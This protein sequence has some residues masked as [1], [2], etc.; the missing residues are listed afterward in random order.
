MS[1]FDACYFCGTAVDAPIATYDVVP[2]AVSDEAGPTAA[3]CPSCKGKLEKV[4]EPALRRLDWP[5]A[6]TEITLDVADES[7]RSRGHTDEVAAEQSTGQPT[8]VR[9][10]DDSNPDETSPSATEAVTADAEASTG[11]QST[12]FDEGIE[13]PPADADEQSEPVV[14][15]EPTGAHDDPIAAPENT[16]ESQRADEPCEDPTA[17]STPERPDTETYN[18]VV[19]L[20]QNR[21]FPVDRSEFETLASSAY[22][23]TPGECERVIDYAIHRGELAESSG[24]LQKPDGT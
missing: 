9:S 12:G 22:E 11:S 17:E 8:T 16:G 2:G 24:M 23:V 7:T 6:E 13:I 3:L 14:D 10:R 18:R 15:D 4:F 20:L 21:E 19:R 1:D 5:G